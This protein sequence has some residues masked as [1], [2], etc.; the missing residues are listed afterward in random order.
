MRELLVEKFIAPNEIDDQGRYIWRDKYGEIIKKWHPET[1][2]WSGL[3]SN[4][5]MSANYTYE[6]VQDLNAFGVD[7]ETTLTRMLSEEIERE[8]GSEIIKNITAMPG[9]TM[10]C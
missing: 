10:T 1:G 5:V 3:D 2:Y 8:I 6:M 7:A 4:R 9:W